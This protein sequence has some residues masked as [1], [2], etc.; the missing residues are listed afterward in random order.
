MGIWG[1]LG[2][3]TKQIPPVCNV[4]LKRYLGTRYEIARL[5]HSF[6][7]GLDNVT[8]TYNFRS[9]GKIEVINAGLKNG[10]KKVTRGVA[11][12]PDKNCTGKILVSFFWPVKSEYKI[13]L[14]DEIDY[15]FAVVTSSTMN[16][17][18]LLS[19]KPKISNEL[20][21]YLIAFASSKGFNVTDI[22]RVEQNSN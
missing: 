16:Y 19:K 1:F 8:A 5:P 6:E 10:G 4:D 15:N 7:K 11:W 12:A 13:I 14:L 17:L 2:K 3:S 20:Y 21:N 18:W 9:D 22:I